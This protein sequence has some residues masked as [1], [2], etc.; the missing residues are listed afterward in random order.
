MFVCVLPVMSETFEEEGS[1]GGSSEEDAETQ[2]VCS[3]SSCPST[4]LELPGSFPFSPSCTSTAS[5][6]SSPHPL[7]SSCPYPSSSASSS[8]SLSSP[9]PAGLELP[10]AGS[11]EGLGQVA[12]VLGPRSECSGASSPECDQE[13]GEC[14]CV[15]EKGMRAMRYSHGQSSLCFIFNFNNLYFSN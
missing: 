12:L 2:S 1:N 14:K 15:C 9:G 4:P 3:H 13:R 7:S 10:D 8:S 11:L 5:S 6:S